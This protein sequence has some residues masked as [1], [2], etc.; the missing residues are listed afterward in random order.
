MDFSVDFVCLIGIGLS[1]FTILS[2][3]LE[4]LYT[5]IFFLITSFILLTEGL[6][7]TINPHVKENF[8][9]YKL[10]N[11]ITVGKRLFMT[12]WRANIY[13]A[14]AITILAVDFKIFP[15]R[16]CKAETFGTGLMDIG[17]G[18]FVMS[19]AMVSPEARGKLAS[20]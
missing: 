17:V 15:R 9:I 14:T 13:T 11:T 20:G 7:S 5:V 3:Q 18:A 12:H 19:N 6:I 1:A 8:H 2:S 16:Y 10:L 4:L